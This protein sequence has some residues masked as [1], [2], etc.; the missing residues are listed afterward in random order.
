[1]GSLRCKCA[2]ADVNLLFI[3]SAKPLSAMWQPWQSWITTP[4][5]QR[6][7]PIHRAIRAS[8]LPLESARDLWYDGRTSNRSTPQ[9]SLNADEGETLYTHSRPLAGRRFRS[10][11]GCVL[12]RLTL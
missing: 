6:A 10:E 7:R 4:S 11:G 2:V 12:E 1:V 9:R 5:N 3:S 8:K